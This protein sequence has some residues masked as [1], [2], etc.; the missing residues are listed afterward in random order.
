MYTDINTYISIPKYVYIKM[1]VLRAAAYPQNAEDNY[2]ALQ[3]LASS[4]SRSN[5]ACRQRKPP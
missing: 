5:C 4:C 2:G 1:H 3:D